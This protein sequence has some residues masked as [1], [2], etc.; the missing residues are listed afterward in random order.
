MDRGYGC[1]EHNS[2][3]A[4]RARVVVVL[5]AALG[6]QGAD[7]ATVSAT[8]DN[9]EREFRID[10][11]EVGVLISVVAL[12]TAVATLPVGILADRTRRTR[13]LA[14]SMVVAG[15]VVLV[16]GA[17]TSYLWL[18]LSRLPL[19]ALIAT[20]VPTVASLTGDYFPVR[21][22][23]RVWGLLL[24]G[25]LLGTGV[26]FVISGELAA[27]VGWRPA[28]WWLVGPC[29]AVGWAAYCLPEP[30][31][32]RQ[33]RLE[34]GDSATTT[35]SDNHTVPEEAEIAH[36]VARRRRVAP[37]RDLILREDPTHRPLWWAVRYILHIRTNLVLIAS[38][39]L[40]YYF[41]PVFSRLVCCLS[42]PTTASRNLAAEAVRIGQ[43]RARGV[44]GRA[45][46]LA[47]RAVV[48]ELLHVQVGQ[49]AMVGSAR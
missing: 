23:G 5:A 47:Q 43:I 37:Q 29:L 10:N 8:A 41:S 7:F 16:S 22:R 17:A 26:R 35:N 12:A 14:I 39:A 3:S 40:G 20:A 34:L 18:V 45:V 28:F 11:I 44:V 6:L 25:E 32:G 15:A 48:D 42:S 36:R 13:L 27:L 19:G 30:G 1:A 2:S 21:S 31:R 46:E 24:G 38:S 49:R 9:L 4:G 33:R